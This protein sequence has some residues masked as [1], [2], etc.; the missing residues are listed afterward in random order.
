MSEYNDHFAESSLFSL[1][2]LCRQSV[3]NLKELFPFLSSL[4]NLKRLATLG[5]FFCN[6]LRR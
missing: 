3:T 2:S 5:R 4:G 6:Y 1:F